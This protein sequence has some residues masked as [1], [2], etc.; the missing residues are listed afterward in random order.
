MSD[1]S[2]NALV[3]GDAGAIDPQAANE[4]ARVPARLTAAQGVAHDRAGEVKGLQP[5]GAGPGES[6]GSKNG[7]D[8]LSPRR[9]RRR[10]ATTVGQGDVPEPGKV[11]QGRTVCRCRLSMHPTARR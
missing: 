3:D 11:H 2:S 6:S 8:V 9:N 4:S 1:R 5:G 7:D 10:V